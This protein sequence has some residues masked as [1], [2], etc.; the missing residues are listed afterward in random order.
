MSGELVL[1]DRISKLIHTVRGQKVMLDSDLA[2]LYGVTVGNLNL[3]VRRN[4]KRFP[5]DFLF[6]L[7]RNEWESLRLQFAILKGGRGRHRKYL[8]YAFTRDGI[9]MLSSALHSERAILINIGIMRAFGR[10]GDLM[11]THQQLARKLDEFEK[12]FDRKIKKHDREI[13]LIIHTLRQL[14]SPA[15]ATKKRIGF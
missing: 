11:A 6:Q 7:T 4:R 15:V 2:T 12:R 13:R 1:V 3:A 10:I 5:E 14:L 8:P 9:S